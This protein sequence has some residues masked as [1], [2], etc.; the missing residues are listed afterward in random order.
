MYAMRFFLDNKYSNR[1]IMSVIMVSSSM[2]TMYIHAYNF[3]L[4][5]IISI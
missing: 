1:L 4:M 3:I 2:E 5:V